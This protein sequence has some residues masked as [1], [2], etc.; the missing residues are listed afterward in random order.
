MGMM[1]RINIIILDHS[2]EAKQT[3]LK[4]N[5]KKISELEG[6]CKTKGTHEESSGIRRLKNFV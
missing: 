5:R 3:D 6:I 4:A 1:V 2:F